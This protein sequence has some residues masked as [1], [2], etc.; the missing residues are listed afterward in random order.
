MAGASP[1]VPQEFLDSPSPTGHGERASIHYGG[2]R[3]RSAKTFDTAEKWAAHYGDQGSGV[4]AA[5]S[6][7][8]G[9]IMGD[10]VG[11]TSR[12]SWTCPTGTSRGDGD[13]LLAGGDLGDLA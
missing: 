12:L 10:G 11:S 4:K 13:P 2:K 1:G 5:K 7:S 3:Y 8:T 9:W 6:S